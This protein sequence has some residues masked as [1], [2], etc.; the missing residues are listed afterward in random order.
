MSKILEVREFDRIISNSVYKDD[1]RYKYLRKKQFDKLIDFIREMAGSEDNDDVLKFMSTTYIRN[2]GDVITIR[3]YVGLIQMDNGFQ[4]EVLPKISFAE[5]NDF[6]NRET[7]QIFLKMLRSMK[8]FP[9]KNFNLA[10]LRVEKMNL[11]E[12]FINMYLQEISYIVK[13]GIKSDYIQRED[14]LYFFK[15]KL[16]VGRNIKENLV[17]KERF[18]VAFDEFHPNRPENRLIKATLLKLQRLTNSFDNA[19]KIRQLLVFFELVKPSVNIE[20]DF[21]KIVINRSNSDYKQILIWSKIFLENKSF[22]SFSGS[23][24]S[25]ALLFPME[26]VYESY[27]SQQLKKIMIP[28]GFEV[29]TQ[30]KGYYLFNK[31]RKQFALRPD[32]VVR[33]DD[34]VIVLDTKWKNLVDN[35]KSNYGISQGDMYQM[36]AYSKKYR[37]KNIWLLYPINN[38]MRNKDQI[39]FI[40]DENTRIHIHFIDLKYI[41]ESIEDLKRKIVLELDHIKNDKSKEKSKIYTYSKDTGNP[42]IGKVRKYIKNIINKKTKMGLEEVKIVAG[43]IHRALNMENAMPTVCNAMKTLGNLYPY[44]I[45]YSPPKGYGSTLSHKYKLLKKI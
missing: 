2:I 1:S 43:D 8:D 19:K 22:S 31:P 35:S 5:E 45:V 28:A 15:G 20:R 7:K 44:E 9:S 41:E 12:I 23:T 21:S 3:N 40:S 29:S 24:K 11:Y 6:D 34:N 37:A 38:E 4:I 32:I 18:Y 25:R 26:Y 10:S 16:L 27:V 33:K 14:S 39:S 36:F 42:P 17:H 13:K 30:D